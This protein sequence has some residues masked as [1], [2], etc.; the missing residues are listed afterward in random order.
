MIAFSPLL[1]T[2]LIVVALIW[3]HNAP[4][5]M[6]IIESLVFTTAVSFALLLAM[7]VID[8][9]LKAWGI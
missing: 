7:P 2:V 1:L 5:I 3:T 6:K 9:I 8:T 4:P